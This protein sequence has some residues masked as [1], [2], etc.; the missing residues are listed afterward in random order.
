[1]WGRNK[2]KRIQFCIKCGFKIEDFIKSKDKNDNN[3]GMTHK[4]G[5]WNAPAPSYSSSESITED[6]KESGIYQRFIKSEEYNPTWLNQDTQSLKISEGEKPIIKFWTEFPVKKEM[7]LTHSLKKAAQTML[8]FSFYALLS[9]FIFDNGKLPLDSTIQ[10]LFLPLMFYIFGSYVRFDKFV[11]AILYSALVLFGIIAPLFHANIIGWQGIPFLLPVIFLNNID[12]SMSNEFLALLQQDGM[13]QAT[14]TIIL[15]IFIIEGILLA[16]H[17]VIKRN[18][19]AEVVL[20]NKSLFIRAKTDRSWWENFKLFFF[21]L[22]NPFNVAAIKDLRDRIKYNKMTAKE[23]RNYDFAR[24]PLEGVVEMEKKE[25]KLTFNVVLCIILG[26][27][28]VAYFFPFLI[29]AIVLFIKTI[30]THSTKTIHIHINNEQAE[31]SWMKIND[32]D[33]IKFLRV[34]PKIAEQFP[35][36]REKSE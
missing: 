18:D 28:G 13:E 22:I 20:T 3:S 29:I 17:W 2:H 35:T 8:W 9:F 12:P 25:N 36:I 4:Q 26:W 14:T 21:V 5:Y 15:Y 34:D 27:F 32:I 1:M 19:K 16:I 10:A 30:R 23:G 11:K 7:S 31:G 24:I 33:I 6:E